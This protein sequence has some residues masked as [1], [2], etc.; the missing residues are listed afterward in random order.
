M[1]KAGLPTWA[2]GARRDRIGAE[3]VDDAPEAWEVVG[4]DQAGV[5]LHRFGW[6]PGSATTIS[7]G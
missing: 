1:G 5:E 4:D 2:R 3:F 6:L 7:S